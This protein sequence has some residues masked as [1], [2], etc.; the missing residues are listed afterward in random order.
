MKEGV[1]FALHFVGS[2][3]CLNF[4]VLTQVALRIFYNILIKGG[5][6]KKGI[7]DSLSTKRTRF[8]RTNLK[9]KNNKKDA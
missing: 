6:N 5:P 8:G 2:V 4:F 7:A 1:D 9:K 3:R